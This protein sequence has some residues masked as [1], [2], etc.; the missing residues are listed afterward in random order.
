MAAASS[1]DDWGGP[2]VQYPNALAAINAGAKPELV[3]DLTQE[4]AHLRL[5]EI[6]KEANEAREHFYSQVHASTQAGTQAPSM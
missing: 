6:E 5:L 2:P 1:G 4:G 3:M